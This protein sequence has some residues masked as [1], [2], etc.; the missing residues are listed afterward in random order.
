MEHPRMRQH[1]ALGRSRG[2][3]LFKH[4][5]EQLQLSSKQVHL[6]L[7]LFL[8]QKDAVCIL[9]EKRSALNTLGKH[10]EGRGGPSG[11]ETC[12]NRVPGAERY[13]GMSQVPH[14]LLKEN[15]A[16]QRD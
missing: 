3:H 13:K 15:K 5:L 6:H 12:S 14:C 11:A 16:I 9:K 8:V 10:R 4:T 2:T 1:P 7:Q